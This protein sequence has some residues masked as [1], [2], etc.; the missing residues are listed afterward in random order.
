MCHTCRHMYGGDPRL[1]MEGP[2]SGV[3][4]SQ[5]VRIISHRPYSMVDM[6]R[7][8]NHPHMG[9]VSVDKSSMSKS[10]SV[11]SGESLERAGLSIEDF[12]DIDPGE[13]DRETH[14]KVCRGHMTFM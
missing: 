6:E 13:E 8:G 11:K 1:A 3:A 7:L 10:G 4:L 12:E 14:H 2:S 5:P 9:G